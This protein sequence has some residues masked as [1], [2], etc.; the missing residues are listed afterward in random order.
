MTNIE[1][2]TALSAIGTLAYCVI[3]AATLI[4]LGVQMREARRYTLAQFVHQLGKE[5]E[6]FDEA[7][8]P[9][10]SNHTDRSG[11]EQQ[12][13]R[14]LQFY[15][16]TKTLCD[17]GVLDLKILD[18]MFGYQFFHLVNDLWV[19]KSV[20]LCDPHYF[21][22]VFALHKQLSDYH[23]RLGVEIPGAQYDLASA[24]PER[25]EKNIQYY[26]EKRVRRKV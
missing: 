12:V 24:N 18:A 26:R 19:Q 7:L 11:L 25:Y 23:R 22:E 4:F 5:F 8:K 16:R 20:L 6:A 14:C 3:T 17:I 10:L 21:P 1:F 9:L 2:W 15:E 13:G